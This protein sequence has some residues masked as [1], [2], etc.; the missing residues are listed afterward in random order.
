MNMTLR[1][2]ALSRYSSVSAFAAAI[3]WPRGK[4]S[5]IL[6][7]TQQPSKRDMEELIAA[8]EI[9]KESVAPIFF[10]AMFTE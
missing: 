7:G 5:R 1:G 4:A 9:P 2:A 8:L 3:G 6:N 10:G